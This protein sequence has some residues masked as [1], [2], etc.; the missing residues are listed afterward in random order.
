MWERHFILVRSTPL[1]VALLPTRQRP[2]PP[3]AAVAVAD[4]MHT[5]ARAH[6][7]HP[8]AYAPAYTT[9]SSAF[10]PRDTSM[11]SHQSF[12]PSLPNIH[13]NN[14]HAAAPWNGDTIRSELRQ[15]IFI[16]SHRGLKLAAKWA[17]EQLIGLPP[18][19]VTGVTTEENANPNNLVEPSMLLFDMNKG[20]VED[21]A[22]YAKSLLDLGEYAHAAA[23]LSQPNSDIT[24]VSP[25]LLDL[26]SFGIYIRAYSLYMAGERKKEEELV[27][28]R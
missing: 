23:V 27:E 22:L 28:L 21:M 13:L 4:A 6:A 9:P 1:N 14:N 25:P 17:S 16:L 7:H 11:T 18:P 8:H 3:T 12:A 5:H 2:M 24:N 26:T 20:P 15:S 10:S 19:P